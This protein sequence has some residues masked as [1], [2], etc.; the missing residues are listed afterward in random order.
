MRTQAM[1]ISK[2]DA[3]RYL[4]GLTRVSWRTLSIR[5]NKKLYSVK[6]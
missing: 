4:E 5:A 1:R 6:N 3:R 2:R